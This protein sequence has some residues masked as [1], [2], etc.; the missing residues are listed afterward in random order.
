MLN[1]PFFRLEKKPGGFFSVTLPVRRG[2]KFIVQALLCRS[3][4]SMLDLGCGDGQ[5]LEA[6]SREDQL[7]KVINSGYEY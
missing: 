3:V 4:R 2:Q 6:R 5:L 7:R 1:P